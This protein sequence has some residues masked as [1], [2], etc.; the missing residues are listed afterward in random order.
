MPD[1]DGI[2]LISAAPNIDKHLGAIVMTGHGTI[3][4]A[5]QALQVGALELAAAYRDLESFS[6]SIS[7][8]LR[9]PLL[10]V[11]GFADML[12]ER[13]GPVLGE[14]GTHLVRVIRDGSHNMDQ[15]IV[16]LLAFSRATRQPLQLSHLDMNALAR[17]ATAEALAVYEGP[18]ARIDIEDLPPADGDSTVIRHV[19][20][21]L[22][23]NAL[24]YSARRSTPHI[25]ISGRIEGNETIYAVQDNGVGFDMTCADKLF[26][27]F[28]RLHSADDYA[29][30]GVGLAIVHRIITRQQGR[31]WAQGAPDAGA[32]MQFALPVKAPGQAARD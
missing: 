27:V 32:R 31:V 4:T 9:A 25:V 16:G 3:D 10:F 24:K 11:K 2:E 5:V 26:G 30:T 6:Y 29:G 15:M 17:A 18:P 23:G 22:I 8:D 1:M 28:K 20:S 12:E 13:F 14:E 7:H 21:N 19:W